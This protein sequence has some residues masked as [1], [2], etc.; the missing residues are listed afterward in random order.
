MPDATW[1]LSTLGGGANPLQLRD[2]QGAAASRLTQSAHRASFLSI[3]PNRQF[4]VMP[5]F[6]AEE[7]FMPPIPAKT[8]IDRHTR[9]LRSDGGSARWSNNS[10]GAAITGKSVLVGKFVETCLSWAAESPQ[11]FE[12]HLGVEPGRDS[13]RKAFMIERN[14][15]EVLQPFKLKCTSP[16]E[17]GIL[18]MR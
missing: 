6:E 16:K 7:F 8:D 10:P 4:A 18:K 17:N 5:F 9:P 2:A 14:R 12:S 11:A 13:R 15:E 1:P 3:P